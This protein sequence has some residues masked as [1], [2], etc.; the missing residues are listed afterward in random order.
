MESGKDL[1]MSL[2]LIGAFLVLIS[3]GLFG[4]RLSSAVRSEVKF[5]RDL[6]NI[7]N[8]MESELQYR[9][10]PLPALCRL[11]AEQGASLKTVFCTF[12]EELENQVSPDPRSCMDAAIF[13]SGIQYNCVDEHLR[14]LGGSFGKFDLEGQLKGLSIVRQHCTSELDKLEQSKDLKI[15][16][17]RT[18]SICIGV[19]TTILLL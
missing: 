2:K 4:F 15:K 11:G 6:I 18:I 12:A 14:D 8:Y 17:Y 3:C 13:R 9:L 16:N 10:T 1:Y 19:L 5:L 7:L